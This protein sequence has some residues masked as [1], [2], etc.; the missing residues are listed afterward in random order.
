MKNIFLNLALIIFWAVVIYKI[1]MFFYLRKPKECP[2]C[3]KALS[4]DE[5][6]YCEDCNR[7][8]FEN[9]LKG[10]PNE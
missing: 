5:G 7:K 8:F 1:G 6:E 3:G 9:K 4:K 10:K 2:Q